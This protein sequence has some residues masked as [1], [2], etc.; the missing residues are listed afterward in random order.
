MSYA[1]LPEFFKIVYLKT[2]NVQFESFF[3]TPFTHVAIVHVCFVQ[4]SYSIGQPTYNKL[5]V[6]PVLSVMVHVCMHVL[7]T[8]CMSARI[9]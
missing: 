2:S 5:H 9:Q 4:C 3:Q 6:L 1:D 7:D 8:G